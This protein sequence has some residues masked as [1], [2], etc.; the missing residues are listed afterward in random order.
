MSLYFFFILFVGYAFAQIPTPRSLLISEVQG[1]GAESPV[2]GQLVKV[3][4]V[5]TARRG[6]GF[7][8]ESLE[9][10]NDPRTSEGLFVFT[11]SNPP[12]GALPQNVVD[13]TGTVAEF[14]PAAD[15]DSAPLTELVNP[16]VEFVMRTPFV[17]LPE[18]LPASGDWERFEGMRVMQFGTVVG[19]TLGSVNESTGVASSNGVLYLSVSGTRPFRDASGIAGTGLLRADTRSSVAAIGDYVGVAGPLDYAFNNY[20][21]YDTSGGVFA[22]PPTIAIP[23]PAPSPQEF[24]IASMN[25]Q[26][27]FDDKDEPGSADVVVQADVVQRRVTRMARVIKEKLWTPDVIG[28]Q[29]AENIDVLRML[30]TAAGDYDA[31]LVEGNDV[32]GIDVGLLVKRGR[33]QVAGIAQEGKTL[34]HG[35]NLVTN[36][37]PP[38]VA[39]L[40]I[41][42]SP[43]TVIVNHL[44]SLIDVGTPSVD[45][46]RRAQAEF[47]RDLISRL[48]S[49]GNSSIVSIG[50]YNNFQ[51]DPLMAMI[52]SAA[53]GLRNLTDT[54]PPADGY[55][56][57]QDGVTQTLDHV[58]VTNA[59]FQRLTRYQVVRLNADYPEI[60]RNDINRLER[61]SDHDVPIAYF[62]I[63]GDERLRA[64]RITNAA[65]GL[66]GAVAPLEIVSIATQG[67]PRRVFFDGTEA[68]LIDTRSG[69][70]TVV[71]PAD[72]ADKQAVAVR[73]EFG[74]NDSAV[75][76]MPVASSS[77]GMFGILNQDYSINT[78][79][80]AAERGSVVMIFGT[81][82]GNDLPVRVTIG[83]H[84]AEVL[85]A[86]PAPGL[87]EGVAQV[88]ARVPAEVSVESVPI[89]LWVGGRASGSAV[90]LAVR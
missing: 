73:V 55:S 36:D 78:A 56:Y 9:A 14:R 22:L 39:R 45:A 71:V 11:S 83:G 34:R 68:R 3:R 60:Y 90:R 53:G 82:I 47:M 85:Y 81:G 59:A 48:V 57:I 33:I 42:G 70:A 41:S 4:G 64:S 51:F 35:N 24:T 62:S 61:Y 38:L 66:A 27:L 49:E 25:L 31:Y 79:T 89:V 43:V 75:V 10:D 63:R 19:A 1:P 88:N 40:Q 26:R 5:V 23:P 13:V 8:I 21:V 84:N 20:S 58:L 87:V 65:T 6:N 2:T 52:Q 54:L 44:R 37:R 46:K 12:E 16:T 32:G 86:G 30:A 18:V 7:W 50:D 67:V 28:V 80:R 77:P 72:V 69:R 17:R 15:P 74:A 29:E 76:T